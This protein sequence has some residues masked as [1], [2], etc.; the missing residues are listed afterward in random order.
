MEQHY[1]TII[2]APDTPEGFTAVE[3]RNPTGEAVVTM[4]ALGR[5]P[6]HIMKDELPA[7]MLAAYA[8]VTGANAA[9]NSSSRT[10]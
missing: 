9:S 6:V 2:P 7:H 4:H 3:W 1:E 8:Y 10:A 5:D